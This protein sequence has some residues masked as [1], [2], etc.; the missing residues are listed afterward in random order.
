MLNP[1]FGVAPDKAIVGLAGKHAIPIPVK[2]MDPTVSNGCSAL[3]KVE[4]TSG[5]PD[6][7]VMDFSTSADEHTQFD[8]GAPKSWNEGTVS[9]RAIYTHAG[10]QTG[11][12]DGVAWFLQGLA[13]SKGESADQAYGTAVVVTNDDAAAEG[14]FTTSESLAITLAGA[15]AEEDHLFFRLGRDVS[16]AA[17]DLDI[18]ARLIGIILYM[19]FAAGNDQ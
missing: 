7:R 19:T 1:I 12:L 13:V 11:G 5:R 17:D 18:D 8:F 3:T 4:T 9:F 15:P 6:L 16:D 10:G 2:S 14:V